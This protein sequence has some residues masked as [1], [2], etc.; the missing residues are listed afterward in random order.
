MVGTFSETQCIWKTRLNIVDQPKPW[1]QLL[2]AFLL[3]VSIMLESIS[4]V[5]SLRQTHLPSRHLTFKVKFKGQKCQIRS[6]FSFFQKW[7]PLIPFRSR[8]EKM[9]NHD[10]MSHY[11]IKIWRICIENKYLSE[12]HQ[13]LRNSLTH[14]ICPVYRP[15]IVAVCLFKC[16]KSLHCSK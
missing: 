3:Q 5:Q 6:F 7:L 12:I 15:C 4:M 8:W 9:R 16:W 13:F 14:W 1:N 2:M 10:L 11:M